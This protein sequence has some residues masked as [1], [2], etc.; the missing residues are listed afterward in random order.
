VPGVTKGHVR[1]ELYDLRKSTVITAHESD[2]ARLALNSDGSLLAT[3]SDKGTLLR[4]FDTHTGAQSKELRRG[5]DRAVRF[6]FG[7]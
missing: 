4:V 5:V 3:A 7:V 2:L 1:V 6:L